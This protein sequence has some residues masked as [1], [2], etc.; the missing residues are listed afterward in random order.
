M[1]EAEWIYPT[2]RRQP[3]LPL[4]KNMDATGQFTV[5]LQPLEAYAK[6]SPGA[7]LGRM[8]ID[9]TFTGDLS[10]RVRERCSPE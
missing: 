4:K 6:E 9:K 8:S 7:T 10:A 3:Y 1:I 2:I 5:H